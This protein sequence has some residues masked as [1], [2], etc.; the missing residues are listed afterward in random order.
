ML[1][2]GLWRAPLSLF[3]GLSLAVALEVETHIRRLES[4]SLADA[5]GHELA[6]MNQR[7]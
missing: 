2:A 3:T 6:A 4:C 1:A 7:V 5:N